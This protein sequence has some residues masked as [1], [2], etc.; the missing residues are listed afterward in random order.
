MRQ[1]E[2]RAKSQKHLAFIRSLPCIACARDPCGEAA[3]VRHNFEINGERQFGKAEKPHDWRT[4]PLCGWC[5][6]ENRNSQHHVGEV[7]FWTQRA[8]NP[9]LLASALWSNRDSF[10][11]AREIV[12]RSRGGLR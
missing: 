8:I 4:V 6:R 9:I 10:E 1:R 11:V 5:H 12:L 7:E 2:P 3:H